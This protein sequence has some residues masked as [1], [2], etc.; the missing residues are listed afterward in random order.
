MDGLHGQAGV[1]RDSTGRQRPLSSAF[2]E[3]RKDHRHPGRNTFRHL[4]MFRSAIDTFTHVTY[5][6][7]YH[8]P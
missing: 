7:A 6:T 5:L 1:S 2:D 4:P 8:S 3:R